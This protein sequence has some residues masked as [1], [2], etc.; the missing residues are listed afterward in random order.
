M[1]SKVLGIFLFGFTATAVSP[2][3]LWDYETLKMERSRFPSANELIVGKFRRHSPKFYQWRIDDRIKK[4]ENEPDNVSYYDDLA[5]AYEKIGQTNKSIELM[6]KKEKIKP[7]LYETRANLGTFYVHAGEYDKGLVEID[8]AIKINP[9]AHF[10]REVYQRLLVEYVASVRQNG[11]SGLPLF[12]EDFYGEMGESGGFAI[13]LLKKKK[14][15]SKKHEYPTDREGAEKELEA[16]IKGVLGMMR[17]GNFDSPILL[18]ALGDL[19]L[20]QSE[21]SRRLAAR[22]YLKASYETKNAKANEAYR[23]KA[24]TALKMQTVNAD[25][26]DEI[27]LGQVE[28]IFQAELAEGK[29]WYAQIRN[30][31]MSWIADGK[32]PEEQYAAKYYEEPA[33]PKKSASVFVFSRTGIITL[34]ASAIG[35]LLFGFVGWGLFR[36]LTSGG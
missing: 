17:F 6:I 28:E 13:F 30:D 14:F 11:N 26:D 20:S 9:D 5:V 2:T 34:I 35:L 15:V 12:P 23:K 7:G 29:K 22:A 3:C 32:N 36:K 16:A 33:F 25:S 24:R 27:T 18:E 8:K 31:E 4:L 1:M 21:P 10:G 19:L